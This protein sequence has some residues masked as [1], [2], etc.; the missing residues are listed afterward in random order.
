MVEVLADTDVILD[1]LT[2][3]KPFSLYSEQLFM[4]A[5]KK[6]IKIFIS[7]LSFSNL[8]YILR[9]FE[10]PKKAYEILRKLK[11][12]VSVLS[13]DEK[14]IELSLNSGF[15]DFEDAIQ[16]Y[17]AKENEIGYIVTRNIKDYKKAQIKVL[18]AEEFLKLNNLI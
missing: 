5:D 3:R 1:L 12:I 17:T 4:C 18:T 10:N 13:V 15:N 6:T 7:S 8:F 14:I 2:D 11:T 9:K 16:Y